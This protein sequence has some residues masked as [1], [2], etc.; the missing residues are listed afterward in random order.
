MIRTAG[1]CSLSLAWYHPHGVLRGW[2]GGGVRLREVICLSATA[3]VVLVDYLS[4]FAPRH[5]LLPSACLPL[6][7]PPP[8]CSQK[9]SCTTVR[10]HDKSALC[11]SETSQTSTRTQ[12]C[13]TCL[14]LCD[15]V[16]L[17]DWRSWSMIWAISWK[18]GLSV[19]SRLQQSVI[20]SYLN[21]QMMLDANKFI[22]K[23]RKSTIAHI[24][25]GAKSGCVMWQPS[26]IIL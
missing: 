7:P 11:G 26:W 13:L 9:C 17:V 2:K 15:D 10:K 5:R 16:L 22:Q 25:D 3:E 8:P 14:P 6:L 4:V 1:R 24:W 23:N 20:S 19:G 12:V 18:V 21:R